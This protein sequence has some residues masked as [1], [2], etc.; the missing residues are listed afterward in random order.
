MKKYQVTA[1]DPE[2]F[3]LLKKCAQHN[4]YPQHLKIN[5]KKNAIIINASPGVNADEF[6]GWVADHGIS[7][8]KAFGCGRW[9]VPA[10]NENSKHVAELTILQ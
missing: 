4:V 3:A 6:F 1:N 9:T 5:E 7:F 2:T 8:S 10:K